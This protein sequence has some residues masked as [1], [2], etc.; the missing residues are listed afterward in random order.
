MGDGDFGDGASL[1]ALGP[2]VV[3][4]HVLK[5]LKRTHNTPKVASGTEN[6]SKNN[7]QGAKTDPNNAYNYPKDDPKGET[8]SLNVPLKKGQHSVLFSNIFDDKM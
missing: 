4:Q 7:P 3:P 5:C 8:M 6:R 1:A 2:H